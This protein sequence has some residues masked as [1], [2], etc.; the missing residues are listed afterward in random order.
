MLQLNDGSRMSDERS[1]SRRFEASEDGASQRSNTAF[2]F[3]CVNQSIVW[4]DYSWITVSVNYRLF[5]AADAGE[6]GRTPRQDDE[7]QGGDHAEGTV[8]GEEYG[9]RYRLGDT[10]GRGGGEYG[11]RYRL[12]N[13][14]PDEEYCTGGER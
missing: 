9:R 6:T 2:Y 7:A 10:V 13:T 11:M 8:G 14:V 3:S 5:I 1:S 12:G 4:E